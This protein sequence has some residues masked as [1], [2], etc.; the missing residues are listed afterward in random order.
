MALI[1]AEG[2]TNLSSELLLGMDD[3]YEILNK[4]FWVGTVGAAG[5]REKMLARNKFLR[6]RR[7]FYNTWGRQVE[8]QLWKRLL[9]DQEGAESV[10][11]PDLDALI[12]MPMPTEDPEEEAE[13]E[14]RRQ[15][16]AKMRANKREKDEAV[17]SEVEMF[18]D[19]EQV[20]VQ[21][22]VG[23]DVEMAGPSGTDAA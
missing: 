4:S 23:K 11:I 13:K 20:L 5:L 9:K 2:L 1:K 19:L 7:D 14:R 18:E 21:E 10:G 15:A 6:A 17:E 3:P 16:T 8:W 12:K 22:E